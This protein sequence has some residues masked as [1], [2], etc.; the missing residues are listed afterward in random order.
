MSGYVYLIHFDTKI[1]HA[2]HYLGYTIDV[3]RRMAM[4]RRGAGARLME[5]V[6]ERGVTWTIAW[7]RIG[8]RTE[9]RRLKNYHNSAKLCPLCQLERKHDHATRN[10]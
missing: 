4:H 10:T 8:D 3:D 6:K 1:G 9:E 7:V 2:R 5:V